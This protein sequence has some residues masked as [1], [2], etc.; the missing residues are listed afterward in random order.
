ME[1]RDEGMSYRTGEYNRTKTWTPLTTYIIPQ[2]VLLDEDKVC[3]VR[4]ETLVVYVP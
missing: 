1:E 2:V 4:M 3:T